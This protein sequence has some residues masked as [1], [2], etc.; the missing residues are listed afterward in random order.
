MRLLRLLP[1]F[2]LTVILGGCAGYQLGPT[3]GQTAGEKSVQI[4]PFA[5]RTPEAR[6]A[7]A[8]TSALRKEV[9]RDGTFRLV[10]HDPGDIVV[11]GALTR[12]DRREV[13]LVPHDVATAQDYNVSLTAQVTAR[14]R[15]SDKVIFDQAVTS[16]TL[17]RVG[18]DLPSSERQALPMLATELAWRVM[19]LLADGNW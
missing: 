17:V 6:L 7:D 2:C 12:Y 5:N 4:V 15:H 11:T 18:Q 8:V 13:S 3:S 1:A 10:T 9:Q 19:A 14:E 16:H